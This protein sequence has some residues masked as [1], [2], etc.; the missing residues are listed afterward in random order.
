MKEIAQ[1]R[2]VIE[3]SLENIILHI[4]AKLDEMLKKREMDEEMFKFLILLEE[5]INKV[6]NGFYILFI[7]VQKLVQKAGEGKD[8]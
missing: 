7:L 5:E 4:D 2:K 3:N 6:A 8:V 1:I